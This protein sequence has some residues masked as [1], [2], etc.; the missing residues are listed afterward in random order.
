MLAAFAEA[1]RVLGRADY[2]AVAQQNAQFL[3]GTQCGVNKRPSPAH[4]ESGNQVPKYNAYLEDYA[5][6]ADGLLALYQN[7]F[8]EQWFCLGAGT[9]RDDADPFQ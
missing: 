6:L 2:T 7:N 9:G 3:Y 8:D 1:G 5:Y 4:L